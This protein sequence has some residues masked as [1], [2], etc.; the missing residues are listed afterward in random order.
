VDGLRIIAEEVSVKRLRRIRFVREV[1]A[2]EG[3]HG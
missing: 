1:P 2:V 3:G